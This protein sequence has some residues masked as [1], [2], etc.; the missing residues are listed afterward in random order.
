MSRWGPQ[1]LLAE[2]GSERKSGFVIKEV[3]YC[4]I[5]LG[6]LKIVKFG[7]KYHIKHHMGFDFP[8]SVLLHISVSPWIIKICILCILK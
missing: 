4:G 3:L 8:V 7:V 1:W 2:L 5:P 6:V